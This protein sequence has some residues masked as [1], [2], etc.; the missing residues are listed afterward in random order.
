MREIKFRAWNKRKGKFAD[1]LGGGE[2]PNLLRPTELSI[3]YRDDYVWMQYTGLKDKNGKEI[4]Q[5]DNVKY[6]SVEYEVKWSDINAGFWVG[7]VC[8][9]NKAVSEDCEVIGNVYEGVAKS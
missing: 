1:S 9:L 5:S 2:D 4:Y 6:D 7:T 8:P 3:A